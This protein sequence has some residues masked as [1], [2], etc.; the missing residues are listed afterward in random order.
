MTERLRKTPQSRYACYTRNSQCIRQL[1]AS[2]CA[3]IGFFLRNCWR[4]IYMKHGAASNE[5]A[6]EKPQCFNRTLYDSEAQ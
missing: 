6:E 4:P 3:L 1:Q 5:Y 2:R